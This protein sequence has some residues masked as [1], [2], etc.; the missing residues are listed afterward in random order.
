MWG[1]SF[2]LRKPPLVTLPPAGLERVLLGPLAPTPPPKP[3]V[4]PPVVRIR[5][6]VAITV[7]AM[8]CFNTRLPVPTPSP[9]PF[10]TVAVADAGVEAVVEAARPT[11]SRSAA[12][13]VGP[14]S[15]CEDLRVREGAAQDSNGECDIEKTARAVRFRRTRA[16][17]TVY[18]TYDVPGRRRA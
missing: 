2:G 5:V 13:S 12:L 15:A 16:C 1:G 7:F 9:P 11:A 10:P 4:A 6:R 14:A 3:P 18:T 17:K 8:L